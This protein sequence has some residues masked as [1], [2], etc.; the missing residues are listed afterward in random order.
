M[1]TTTTTA[2]AIADSVGALLKQARAESGLSRAAVALRTKIPERYLTL[3]EESSSAEMPED[4]YAKIYFKAYAKFLGF[5]AATLVDLQKKEKARL[6]PP[7]IRRPAAPRQ[8]PT[9]SVPTSAMMVTPKIIQSAL[10]ALAL[11]GLTLYFGIEIKKIIAPPQITL[12][13]PQDGL[14]TQNH[15][16]LVEGSTEP[17]VTLRINGKE[18]S[19]D[20]DGKFQDT[21]ALQE[22]LNLI[23]V[24]GVK[25]HS[26]EM[27]VTRRIIVTPSEHPAAFAPPTDTTTPSL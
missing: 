12:T 13:S 25:K 6:A 15:S 24:S 22:G 5:D 8:H 11:I 7:T 9:K 16:L 19:P 18:I 21:L 2:T 4:V 1:R 27:T 14:V 10:L 17:E 3:F 23:T 26:K 20:A